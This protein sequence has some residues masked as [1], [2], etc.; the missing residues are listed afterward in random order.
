MYHDKVKRCLKCEKIIR[1]E[2]LHKIATEVDFSEL[3]I[4]SEAKIKKHKSN[5][6]VVETTKAEGRKCPVCWKITK[7]ACK[8]H[9]SL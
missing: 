4:T 5:E 6:I 3:C 1:D 8:R 9:P 7:D 2:E